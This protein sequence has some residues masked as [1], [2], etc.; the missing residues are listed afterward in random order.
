MSGYSEAIIAHHGVLEEHAN[1]IQKPFT[2][3]NLLKKVRA[4]LDTT[5]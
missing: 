3:E 2:L 5:Q 1:F 4:I